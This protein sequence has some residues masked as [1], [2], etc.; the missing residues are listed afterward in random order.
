MT[1]A[2]KWRAEA[3]AAERLGKLYREIQAGEFACRIIECAFP[4]DGNCACF[5][6]ALARFTSS[7]NQKGELAA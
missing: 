4:L 1:E 3:E 7:S 6:D 2:D 5:N